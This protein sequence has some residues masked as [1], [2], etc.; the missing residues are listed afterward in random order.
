MHK[1]PFFPRH[2]TLSETMHWEAWSGYAAPGSFVLHHEAEY[3]AIRAAAGL[4]DVTPLFKY[5]VSGPDS[6]A[7]LSHIMVRDLTRLAVGNA[8]YLCW[9][10]GDGKVIDDGVAMRRGEEDFFVTSAEPCYAWFSRHRRGYRVELEEVTDCLAALALQGP[11]SRAVLDQVCDAGGLRF[12]ETAPARIESA[13]VWVSRTGY[14]GDLGFE[15]WMDREHALPIWDAL[16]GA[17]RRYAL[18]PAGLMALDICRIEAGLILKNV[19]YYNALHALIDSRK[20]SPYEIALGWT[21]ELGRN[22]FIG[23][24]ALQREQQRGSVWALVGLELDWQETERLYAS[25]GLPP[26]VGSAARRRSVPIYRD[27]DRQ[28]QIGYVTSA[29]W[30]PTLQKNIALATV[31]TPFAGLG[32]RLQCELTVEHVRYTV[33]ATVCKPQ[34]YRPPHKTSNPVEGRT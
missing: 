16:V 8:A 19:D 15:L 21:V 1:T 5:R 11:A 4:I 33:T 32:S 34:F 7:F 13:P 28:R 24:R 29:T 27:R 14:T 20:S 23:Q 10:D 12:F 25:H 18:R 22:P 17:G 31:R 9:C 26:H 3:F 30:S 6:A 2:L